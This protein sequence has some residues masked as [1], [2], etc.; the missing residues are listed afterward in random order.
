MTT[1]VYLR[2]A[3]FGATVTPYVPFRITRLDSDWVKQ[4]TALRSMGSWPSVLRI[5]VRPLVRGKR[6]G[7]QTG[8]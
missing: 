3:G 5:C 6:P 8:S 4:A 7:S 2:L 1:H